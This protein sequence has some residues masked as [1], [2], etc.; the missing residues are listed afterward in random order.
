MTLPRV[1]PFVSLAGCLLGT[2]ALTPACSKDQLAGPKAEV[3]E[4]SEKVDVPAVPAETAFA[5]VK[6]DDGS[7]SIK[8]LRVRLPKY[9][10]QTLSVRGFIVKT[11]SW[12]VDCAPTIKKQPGWTDVE[13]NA[14]IA[15]NPDQCERIKF[16]IGDS[17]TTPDAQALWVVDVPRLPTPIELKNIP[18]EELAD[19]TLW[20]EVV[21]YDV[22]DEV[23]ITGAFGTTSPHGENNARGLITYGT[24]KN[25]T[26]GVETAPVLDPGTPAAP[27]ATKAA[28]AH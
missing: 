3:K 27:I 7:K 13:I 11:Y 1:L 9:D 12:A 5:F 17:K 16:F 24:M 21:P 2:L 19:K 22:G 18:K 25:I 8:E 6:H 20:K 10:G 15:A 26:K 23:V 4:H 28:P 14:A